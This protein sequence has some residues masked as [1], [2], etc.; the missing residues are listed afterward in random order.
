ML[1][2]VLLALFI[3]FPRP[4]AATPDPPTVDV[5]YSFRLIHYGAT[6]HGCAV[7]GLTLT[8]R[9]M[10]DPRPAGEE[11]KPAYKT[12]FRYAFTNEPTNTE[13]RGYSATISSVA[14]LAIVKLDKEPPFGYARLAPTAP[15]IGA[16]IF[17]IEY[18]FRTVENIYRVRGRKAKVVSNVAGILALDQQT[19]PGSSGGCAYNAAG[20]V[21]GLIAFYHKAENGKRAGGIVSLYGDWWTDVVPGGVK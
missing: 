14:D 5:S 2:L 1:R 8:N 21:V 3:F 4:I 20:E 6:G 7:N 11:H 13:G 17:W 15:A 16:S 12:R 9:H 10:V 18:D 19:N